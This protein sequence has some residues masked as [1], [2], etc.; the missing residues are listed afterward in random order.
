MVVRDYLSSEWTPILEFIP[1]LMICALFTVAD[2]NI[3][4]LIKAKLKSFFILKNEF[5]KKGIA[6]LILLFLGFLNVEFNSLIKSIVLISLISFL[7]SVLSVIRY[8]KYNT[9]FLLNIIFLFIIAI[10]GWS[11]L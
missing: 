1:Y 10:V 8:L 7:I 3:R 11:L 5:L 2:L 9:G 4:T 6:L